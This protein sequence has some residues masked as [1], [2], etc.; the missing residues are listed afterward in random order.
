MTYSPTRVLFLFLFVSGFLLM[1]NDVNAATYYMRADGSA[2]FKTIS[3]TSNLGSGGTVRVTTSSSHGYSQGDTVSIGGIVGTTEANGTWTVSN[4]SDSTH[5]DI[6]VTYVNAWSSGGKVIAAGPCPGA[7]CTA[8]KTMSFSTE[9]NMTTSVPGDIFYLSSAGGDYN[10]STLFP[11][12]SG[13][14]NSPIQFKN[15][16]GESPTVSGTQ[17]V[18]FNGFNYITVDGLTFTGGSTYAI[19]AGSG[20][21]GAVIKNITC[22]TTQSYC[23][24]FNGA[25]GQIQNISGT[26]NSAMVYVLNS[27]SVTV[28]DITSSGA[29]GIA[30][31]LKSPT[32]ATVNNITVSHIKQDAIRIE[33]VNNMSLT[34]SNWNIS[35]TGESG[36]GFQNGVTYRGTG[37]TNV[38][39]NLSNINISHS[40]DIGFQFGYN[41][42]SQFTVGSKIDGFDISYSQSYGIRA[43]STP[44]LQLLNGRAHHNTG[45]AIYFEA[46][47]TNV[48]VM[49]NEID[50]NGGDGIDTAGTSTGIVVK[51]NNVHDNGTTDDVAG[52]AGDGFSSHEGSTGQ[53]VMNNL[54]YN[55]LDTGMAPVLDS[56]GVAYNNILVNNGCLTGSTG[57]TYKGTRGGFYNSGS[58]SWTVKNNII[59]GS[60][61]IEINLT[62]IVASISSFDFNRYYHVGNNTVESTA[63]SVNGGVTRTSWSTYHNSYEPN[64]SY[65]DPLFTNGTGSYST[66]TDF[67]LKELSPAIDAGVVTSNTNSTTTDYVGNPIYGTP[68]I[69]AYEYQPPYSLSTNQPEYTGNIRIYGDRK[70]R[71]TVATT[72]TSRANFSVAPAETWTYAASTTRPAWLDISSFTWNTSG[73]YFKQ[74]TA[75]STT[76][77]TT[78]YTIGDLLPSADYTVAVDGLASTT[79]QSNGSGVLTYTYTGGYSTHVFTVSDT[80]AP[81]N[82]AISSVTADSPNQLTVVASTA[83]DAGSGLDST[84]YYFNE[85]T[86]NSGGLSSSWQLSSTFVASGLSPNT[87]YGYK[88]KAKDGAGNVSSYSDISYKYTLA[89]TPTGFRADSGSSFASLTVDVLQNYSTGQSGYLFTNTT[90]G[91]SSGWVQT[92]T[93][94]NTGLNC[95]TSYT[96]TVKYRNSEGVETGSSSVVSST[97]SCQNYGG[98][99]GGGGQVGSNNP[100]YVIPVI[101]SPAITPIVYSKALS[102]GANTADVRQLQKFLNSRGYIVAKTGPGSPGNE[103]TYF[104]ALT[105]NALIR[106]QLANKK[107]IL[108]SQ[109]I[110]SPTGVLGAYTVKVIN[111]MLRN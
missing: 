73:S 5:F 58:G 24:Y 103:T 10:A 79:V 80:T 62:S 30:L 60:Y 55:N 96:Y 1:A 38:T 109:G 66:S 40:N 19:T 34:G 67:Q 27:P 6:P 35:Y 50:H 90:T 69:G 102:S 31:W 105:K 13:T 14:S 22:N 26:A 71:Y 83:T 23:V 108:D 104:G 17:R 39:L 93:W 11:Q 68:D 4:V 75:S 63:F 57:C 107:E 92:N 7:A 45:N 15:V 59:Q 70:Y 110:K 9:G 52:A 77:T 33:D 43:S 81:T 41:G 28:S 97:S 91:L 36:S 61:P 3:G 89:P 100:V 18:S 84:P 65:G 2:A 76:A 32:T 56:A 111:R 37:A 20:V 98:G 29:N 82:I 48:V 54:F 99:G 42:G 94:Q 106:F 87:R 46:T 95:G 49:Y 12:A 64:S 16:T 51:Y 101:P 85:T 21:V 8:A 86:G 47:S 88:V 72:S 25:S 78:V 44:N 74:W 53:V